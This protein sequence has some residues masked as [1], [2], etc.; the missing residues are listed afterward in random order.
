MRLYIVIILVADLIILLGHGLSLSAILFTF[1]GTAAVI[2]LDG[3]GAFF[4]RQL[5]EKY[6]DAEHC[7]MRISKGERRFYKRIGIKTWKDGIPELG[8]FTGF[9]KNKVVDRQDS[10]Y[11]GRFIL[12]SN[13]GVFI[14]I[15]NALFGLLLLA[16]LPP[17]Y[18]WPIAAVN[19]VLSALPV[20]V[21]RYNLSTLQYLYKKARA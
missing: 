8:Q 17:S 10:V 21:L 2:A 9:H 1:G 14:H 12:E 15:Q 3:L 5:P 11:L 20:F 16:F 13:Y 18:A 7:H 4:I 19:L 6:F